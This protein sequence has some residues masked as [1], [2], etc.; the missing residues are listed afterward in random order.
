MY[1]TARAKLVLEPGCR[2]YYDCPLMGDSFASNRFFSKYRGKYANFLEYCKQPVGVLDRKGRLPG[3]Y[4]NAEDILVEFEDGEK[5]A[6]NILHFIVV[7]ASKA[8]LADVSDHDQKMSD[9]LSPILLYPGD[10]VR[11]LSKSSEHILDD[12]GKF[13]EIEEVMFDEG[14]TSFGTPCYGVAKTE[15]TDYK[16]TRIRT[17]AKYKDEDLTVVTR[18]N[19]WA[20]YTDPSKLSFESDEEELVFWSHDGISQMI[21]DVHADR[22]KREGRMSYF[23]GD[24]L[25]DSWKQFTSDE[26]DI[27]VEALQV[28]IDDPIRYNARRLHDCFAQHRERVR[29]VTERLLAR[30]V[31]QSII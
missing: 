19:V 14:V 5:H 23:F 26:A 9:L 29:A 8:K 16:W 7:D 24:S 27:I 3:F 17:T 4:V 20:L 11:F 30:Q 25:E 1:I 10:Q 28:N 12:S 18:G 22:L 15:V 2:L 13:N 6:L 31:E 21:P